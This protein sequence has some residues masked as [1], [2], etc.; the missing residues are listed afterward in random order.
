MATGLEALGAASAVLQV[1][2]FASDLANACKNAY[3]GA[4]TPQDDLEHHAKQMFE[5]VSRVET[6]CQLMVNTNSK[7]TNPELQN[8]AQECKDAAGKL[9]AEVQYV[10][11]MQARGNILKSVRKAWRASSRKKKLDA[12]EES[13][14]RHQ[15]V[16]KT[17]LISQSDA[18]HLQ[19]DGSFRKLDSDVQ[20]LVTQLAQGVTDVLQLL[21]TEHT[22]TRT[23]V[24]QETTR[25]ERAINKNTNMQVL[26]LKT[27]IETEEQCKRFL[28]SLKADGMNQRYNDV[29]ES[30]YATFNQVFATYQKMTEMYYEDSED[31][32]SSGGTSYSSCRSHLDEIYES[33]DSFNS[34]LQRNETLFY[35]QGKPGSGKSTLVKFILE[36][37]HTRDLLQQ[38]STDALIISYFFWKIGSPQQN[39]IKGLWCTLLYQILQDHSSLIQKVLQEF[40]HLSRHV[41]YHDWTVKDLQAVWEYIMSLDNLHL[42]IFIDGLDEVRDEDGFF[43]LKESILLLT[44]YPKT[45]LCVSTRPEAQIMKWVDQTSASGFCLEDLTKLDMIIFVRKELHPLLGDGSHVFHRLHRG[46]VDKAQ[47]VFLW[48]YLAIKSIVEGINNDDPEDML[49]HRLEG[50]P[51]DLEQLYIDMWQR[52]NAN[53]PVYRRTAARYFRY[54]LQSSR[55]DIFHCKRNGFVF[56]PFSFQIACAENPETQEALLASR[57]SIETAGTL[58]MCQEITASIRIRCA[59]LLEF[60]PRK[61]DLVIDANDVMSNLFG[62]ITFIHR[63]AHD[64]LLDTEAGRRILG[65]ESSTDFSLRYRLLKGLVC[66]MVVSSS[67]WGFIWEIAG[68][69]NKL[70]AFVKD[71]G[72]PC[73]QSAFEIL[74]AIQPMYNKQHV[75]ADGD[76]DYRRSFF[77]LLTHY[78]RFDDFVISRL[79]EANSVRMATDTLREGWMPG[80]FMTLSKRLYDALLSLGADPHERGGS[81]SYARLGPFVSKV[82][83][84]TNLVVSFYCTM[85]SS[86]AAFR[87]PG[88]SRFLDITDCKSL[89]QT[90]QCEI[91]EMAIHMARSC[92]NLSTGVVLVGDFIGNRM[93]ATTTWDRP[94]IIER[95]CLAEFKPPGK[96]DRHFIIYEVNIQF[97]LLYL[98]LRA[99]EGS[100]ESLLGRLGAEDLLPKVSSPYVKLRYFLIPEATQAMSKNWV[101]VTYHRVAAQASDLRQGFIESL[102]QSAVQGSKTSHFSRID[103]GDQ[104]K[105]MYGSYAIKANGNRVIHRLKCSEIEDVDFETM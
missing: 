56:S 33:W 12:L 88:A 87:F 30:S 92:K 14:S 28:Q 22:T 19:Q 59:G 35:I 97:L 6:R 45:K 73:L 13:L 63:T 10:T 86:T 17:E 44:K 46:L 1:L 32:Q 47:G 64:F 51:G 84:F 43:R 38:W 105:E 42:C 69:I 101:R 5:A 102:L 94:S 103:S 55:N 36:Q 75:K 104:S 53:N 54:V 74:D 70:T 99:S 85:E 95:L 58:R 39:S 34:W 9:Q 93:R 90:N 68:V 83:A 18:I 78:D 48:L 100:V 31:Y 71:W 26:E 7:F 65:H 82:T 8:I 2:S 25:A 77:S 52:L 60:Q 24:T 50:L 96:Y 66:A 57:N 11:S 67:Q 89:N 41:H 98:L 21:R 29:M 49:L 62:R 91:L 72:N 15:Q 79:A 27:R 23:I 4:T 37:E 20:D 61:F 80:S 81:P 76:K 3:D 16:M 40:D